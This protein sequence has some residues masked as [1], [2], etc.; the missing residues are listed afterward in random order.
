MKNAHPQTTEVSALDKRI[1]HDLTASIK[2]RLQAGE[3]VTAS[4]YKDE[5]RALYHAAM[6]RLRD[7]L[8]IKSKWRTKT[9]SVLGDWRIRFRVYYLPAES[10]ALPAEA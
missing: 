9:A 6:A 1:L 5:T 10:L 4:D 8:P 7:Q 3:A 2:A